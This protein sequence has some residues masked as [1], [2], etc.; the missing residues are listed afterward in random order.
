ML[1]ILIIDESRA[2]AAEL[3][4]ALAMAGHQV[5]AVLPSALDLTS[6]TFNHCTTAKAIP[7]IVAPQIPLGQR[8]V[9]LASSFPLS[10]GSRL[11]LSGPRVA[12]VYSLTSSMTNSQEGNARKNS[13]M[14]VRTRGGDTGRP[15]TS[16]MESMIDNSALQ[17]ANTAQI[18]RNLLHSA[19]IIGAQPEESKPEHKKRHG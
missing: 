4:A 16:H 15:N 8:L 5:G 3:C 18:Q 6:P 12:R 11:K 7:P 19:S 1:R 2:R 14:V 9:R 13:D 17:P 10:P